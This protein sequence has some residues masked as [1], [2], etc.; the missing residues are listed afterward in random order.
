MKVATTLIMIS[1]ACTGCA[2][3]NSI[4]RQIDLSRGQTPL[5]DVRQRAI[6]VVPERSVTEETVDGGKRTQRRTMRI[7]V[8]AEPSPDAMASFAYELAAKATAKGGTGELAAAMQDSAAFVGLRTQSIQLLRDFGYRL[9]EGYM[10]GAISSEQYDLLMRRFQKNTVALL[11]IE[12]LTGAVKAPPVVLTS[13]G[14]AEVTKSILEMRDQ[15][16]KINDQITELK[17]EEESAKKADANADTTAIAE[18]IKRLTE[19][20]DFID[21]NIAGGKGA[22]A[23]GKTD[24]KLDMSSVPA[25]RSD[26]HIASVAATVASIVNNIVLS[27]DSIQ[28][29]LSAMSSPARTGTTNSDT[30]FRDWCFKEMTNRTATTAANLAVQEARIELARRLLKSGASGTNLGKLQEELGEIQKQLDSTDARQ[31]YYSVPIQRE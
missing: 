8:C 24:V 21:K 10:S 3:W 31:R 6:L 28:L 19:D 4:Y 11:A 12:Q 23:G 7:R 17:K 20:R 16:E 5:I 29:C 13:Q 22:L 26:Q 9:C 30:S 14:A 27:D 18:K 15:R 1:I 2:N 25:Q